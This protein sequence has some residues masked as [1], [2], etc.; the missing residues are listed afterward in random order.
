MLLT[1]TGQKGDVP[2]FLRFLCFVDNTVIVSFI[3]RGV[4]LSTFQKKKVLAKI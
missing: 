1:E 3:P 2:E 4:D